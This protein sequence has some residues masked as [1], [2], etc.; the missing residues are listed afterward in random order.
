MIQA[1]SNFIC[2]TKAQMLPIPSKKIVPNHKIGPLLIHM[3]KVTKECY[4]ADP[5]IAGDA[6]GAG[7]QERYLDRQRVTLNKRRG[8]FLN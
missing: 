4:E 6:Q 7:F 1:V 5:E 8:C 2:G 3:L